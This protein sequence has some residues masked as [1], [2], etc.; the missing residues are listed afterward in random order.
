MGGGSDAPAYTWS[1]IRYAPYIEES[2]VS[3]YS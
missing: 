2:I 1:E 3:L